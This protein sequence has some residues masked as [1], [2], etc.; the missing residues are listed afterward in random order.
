M[1][2]QFIQFIILSLLLAFPL[3]GQ[4]QQEVS[5]HFLADLLGEEMDQDLL[6]FLKEEKI[7]EQLKLS[8]IL[9][10]SDWRSLLLK[11]ENRQRLLN[12]LPTEVV[13]QSLMVRNRQIDSFDVK[14]PN[15]YTNILFRSGVQVGQIPIKF[16]GRLVSSDFQFQRKLSNFSIDFNPLQYLQQFTEKY[17]PNPA[18]LLDQVSNPSLAGLNKSED[19]KQTL[20][21]NKSDKVLLR[22]EIKFQ[23][24][25]Y[26]T[27]H[28]SFIQLIAQRDSLQESTNTQR[29]YVQN[30]KEI[31]SQTVDSL[32]QLANNQIDKVVAAK[33]KAFSMPTQLKDSLSTIIHSKR[34]M[35]DSILTLYHDRWEE[36]KSYYGDTLRALQQKLKSYADELDQF[37]DPTFLKNK[38]LQDKE[39]PLYKRLLA[40]SERISIG[41]SILDDS[42]YTVKNLPFTGVQYGFKS[43]H[44]FSKVAYGKQVYN[45]NF[46]PIW[47]SQLFH[48]IEGAKVLFLKGGY[49]AADQESSLSYTFIK[50]KESGDF[51]QGNI[52]APKNNTVFSIDGRG[53]IGKHTHLNGIFSFSRS[54]WGQADLS[55]NNQINK[56]NTA[57]EIT[58]SNQLFAQQVQME[59]GFFYVGANFIA[60]ANPFL[61]TNQQGLV[62]KITGKIGQ[63]L[64]VATEIK[65]GESIDPSLTGGDQKNLQVLG[66]FNWR[67]SN[68]WSFSGQIAPNTFKHFGT[69][70][71]AIN[72][73]NILYNAQVSAQYNKENIMG[74][75]TGGFTNYN[76]QWQYYDTTFV[77]K[78]NHLFL[79]KSLIFSN[80]STLSFM[81]MMGFS[82]DNQEIESTTQ[83]SFFSEIDYQFSIGQKWTSSAGIQVLKDAF[84]QEWM[85]GI[86]GANEITITPQLRFVIDFTYQLPRTKTATNP[87]RFWG[88]LELI[89]QF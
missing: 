86:T 17:S 28:P 68:R 8:D 34:V 72:S 52:L 70:A 50:V 64:E 31:G 83:Q 30:Q 12:Q 67:P 46:S 27:T 26:V 55:I 39:L 75:V 47:S 89:K 42:W 36:R 81:S 65:T 2:N 35:A 10:S 7:L 74:I 15:N 53:K 37:N 58:L 11:K 41:Q 38:L 56:T 45:T 24:Y 19:L 33:N 48:E 1:R 5:E 60:A 40:A 4:A 77:N 51:S 84:L 73:A 87:S 25:Q 88:K 85:Y 21:F 3:W 44:F 76:T 20:P 69:G 22:K 9:P 78:T 61:Q 23:V 57:G 29:A 71:I 6:D 59:L 66:S 62:A 82:A 32:Q 14:L 43:G 13:L 16:N 18:V 79:Q 54:A 49:R 80:Q 63:Q